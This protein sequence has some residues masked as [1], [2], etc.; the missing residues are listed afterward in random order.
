MSIN[1]VGQRAVAMFRC[2]I[3]PMIGPRPR[4]A[5]VPDDLGMTAEMNEEATGIIVRMNGQEHFIFG[6]NIQSVRFKPYEAGAVT[7]LKTKLKRSG[8]V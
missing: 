3:D 1:K 7:E 4:N 6:A 5:F 2:Q 8:A